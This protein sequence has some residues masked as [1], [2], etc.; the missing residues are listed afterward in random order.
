[1]QSLS[2][3]SLL[4]QIFLFTHEH[5]HKKTGSVDGDEINF[6]ITSNTR[7]E[8][9]VI[10]GADFLILPQDLSPHPGPSFAVVHS[11]QRVDAKPR[12]ALMAGCTVAR[13]AVRIWRVSQTSPL[14]EKG[15]GVLDSSHAFTLILLL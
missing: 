14:W 8:A 4:F 11:A 15:F 9:S 2:T 7:E 13:C 3:Q 5:E 1:M 6:N 12:C 10:S